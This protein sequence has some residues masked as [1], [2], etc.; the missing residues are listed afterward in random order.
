M[1]LQGAVITVKPK[2][3]GTVAQE[4]RLADANSNMNSINTNN[5][6]LDPTCRKSMEQNA[7]AVG[8]VLELTA[9]NVSSL[10]HDVKKVAIQS[11]NSRNYN[12]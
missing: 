10:F 3:D 9:R 4:Q 12:K 11:K 8:S 7:K 1:G 6:Y 5:I 2:I